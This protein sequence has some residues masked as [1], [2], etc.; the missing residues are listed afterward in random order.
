MMSLDKTLLTALKEVIAQPCNADAFIPVA[1]ASMRKVREK[2]IGTPKELRTLQDIGDREVTRR[3]RAKYQRLTKTLKTYADCYRALLTMHKEMVKEEPDKHIA[4]DYEAAIGKAKDLWEI[5]IAGLLQEKMQTESEALFDRDGLPEWI[6][7]GE[8]IDHQ[9][10][11]QEA[12]VAFILA[13]IT[14][15]LA[16]K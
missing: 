7:E 16:K 3:L 8:A 10:A 14:G 9:E 12:L 15:V 4:T 1:N 2:A 13:K 11:V 6:D 5:R